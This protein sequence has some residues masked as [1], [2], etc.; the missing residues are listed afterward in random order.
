MKN[1][2]NC[3]HYVPRNL[4]LLDGLKVCNKLE[5]YV[6]V[7]VADDH[8]LDTWFAPPDWF[9]CTLHKEVK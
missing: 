3:T 4:Y 5:E 8:G 1:C 2:A 6:E 9:S 7:K